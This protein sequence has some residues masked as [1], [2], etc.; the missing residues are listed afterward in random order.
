MKQC[1]GKADQRVSFEEME[2]KMSQIDASQFQSKLMKI[3]VEKETPKL[4]RQI[5]NEEIKQQPVS[6]VIQPP[7]IEQEIWTYQKV[8]ETFKIPE[9]LKEQLRRLFEN[10]PRLTSLY[11]GSTSL[12]NSFSRQS[13]WR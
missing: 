8:M 3:S 13:N 10:D 7:K 1:L 11:L 2:K 4:E 6:K 9:K 12:L 5:K